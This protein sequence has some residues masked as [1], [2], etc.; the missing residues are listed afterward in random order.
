MKRIRLGVGP[1]VRFW[2]LAGFKPRDG[3]KKRAGDQAAPASG[4]SD[5][6]SLR[7]GDVDEWIV[8]ALVGDRRVVEFMAAHEVARGT[9]RVI[10]E[11]P[12]LTV[13]EMQLAFGKARRVRE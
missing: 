11:E 9:Q 3:V 2:H 1:N 7:I 10:A 8:A 5:R 6:P 4:F 13:A 12:R